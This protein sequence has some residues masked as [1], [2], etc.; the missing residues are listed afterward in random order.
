MSR[1]AMVL[2]FAKGQHISFPYELGNDL[3]ADWPF[4]MRRTLFCHFRRNLVI[5][6]LCFGDYS[7]QQHRRRAIRIFI[8][9]M[10]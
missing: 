8:R 1:T 4:G 2:D 10:G 6:E 3:T 9:K 5:V 7:N